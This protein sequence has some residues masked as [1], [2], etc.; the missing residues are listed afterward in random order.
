MKNTKI[1][2]IKF[3]FDYKLSEDQKYG[4]ISIVSIVQI[5]SKICFRNKTVLSS[6]LLGVHPYPSPI[7]PQ[8]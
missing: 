7:T 1:K 3:L 4:C 8:F 6:V 2:K 5:K